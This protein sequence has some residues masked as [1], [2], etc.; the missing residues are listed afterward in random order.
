MSKVLEA[1]PHWD[2][3]PYFPSIESKEFQNA[4]DE[5]IASIAQLEKHFDELGICPSRKT[6]N[7]Q[8]VLENSI[9]QIN[10]LE[11]KLRLVNAYIYTFI[12]TDSK[13]EKAQALLS[14][15]QMHMAQLSKLETRWISWLSSVS[16]DELK[17]KSEIIDQ[18]EYV[19]SKKQTI[20][21][22][23]M[24]PPEED[25]AADMN[26]TG[27]SAWGRLHGNLTSQIEVVLDIGEG[28]TRMPM[29]AVRNLAYEHD[30]EVRRKAYEAE[31]Q[32][33][34][35]NELTIAT[36]MNGIKG[37]VNLLSRKRN[38]QSPLDEALF[39]AAIDKQTLEAMLETAKQE[40]PTLRRYLKAKAKAL[41]LSKCAWYDIFAP[42]PVTQ[43]QSSTEW[44]YEK[45]TQFVEQNF[46][47]FSNR[48]GDLALRAFKENWIDAEPRAGKRDGAFCMETRKG[49]SRILMNYK[50]FYGSVSTLAHE[51]GHAYHNLCLFERTELQS[52]TPMTLAETASIFC[53]AIIAEEYM[54][55]ADENEKLSLLESSLQR[56]CQTVVDIS[57]RFIFESQVFESRNQRELSAREMCEIMLD[58]QKQTYGDGLDENFLH[59]Y[60]WAVK[61]H[62]YSAGRSFYNFPYMFGM[63]FS[64]GLYAIYKYDPDSFV[65]KYDDMLSSTGMSTAADLAKRFD[66][67]IRSSEF[68]QGS[69]TKI[70]EMVDEF[71]SII[72]SRTQQ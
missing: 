39:H 51:L 10:K 42:L 25:L 8:N 46:R 28:E 67:D 66:M 38:W 37:Q 15:L 14:Q 24:T 5:V 57:S 71:E 58:A 20:A 30:R 62:Y 33:W 70:R 63:L 17:A 22:H 7:A 23:L 60:M 52:E 61:P 12:T 53:E 31:L 13:D 43:S 11:E 2:V 49:E 3:T 54:K 45:A 4:F 6:D 29:S 18:H 55:I 40:F 27:G 50:P 34:K 35:Q 56:D 9:I 36:C 16:L 47:K 64:M 65:S 72:E 44:H 41:G 59:P 26:L 21:A 1:L 32:A 48:M 69:F 68:W 19:L